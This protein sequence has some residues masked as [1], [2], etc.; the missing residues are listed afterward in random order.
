MNP[1]IVQLRG[2]IFLA[3]SIGY[4]EE[5][6]K[7]YASLLPGSQVQPVMPP[8][9]VAG[10]F[11]QGQMSMGGPWQLVKDGVSIIFGPNQVDI[12]ENRSNDRIN[13]EKAFVSFC[14]NV[15]S[16]ITREVEYNTRMA[17]APLFAMDEDDSFK[18]NEW[19]STMFASLSQGGASMQDINLT[20]VLKKGLDL[21]NKKVTLNM[22]HKIY[23]GYKYNESHQVLN[24]SIMINLD[25][26][27]VPQNDIKLEANDVPVFFDK[28]M[29]EKERLMK[30]YFGI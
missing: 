19:W 29:K 1:S 30:N 22:H 24:K 17:Y 20:Y 2:T 14:I 21:N 25:I 3:I 9:Q 13:S 4:S 28:A 8:F 15:F 23:D 27:T 12:I 5:N 16:T 26:N 18:C 11:L 10:M 7:K 6:K